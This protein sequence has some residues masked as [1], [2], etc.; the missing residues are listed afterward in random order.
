[1]SV[2]T[3]VAA[4]FLV[5]ASVPDLLA[6]VQAFGHVPYDFFAVFHPLPFCVKD[7]H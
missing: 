5:D 7:G 2:S 6:A 4:V 3:V 1:M